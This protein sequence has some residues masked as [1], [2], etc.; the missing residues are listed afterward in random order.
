VIV[1]TEVLY[2]LWLWIITSIPDLI[3]I[4]KWEWDLESLKKV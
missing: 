4:L 1:I 2:S 3:S